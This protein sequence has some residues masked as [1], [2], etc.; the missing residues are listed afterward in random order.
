MI[1]TIG[2][3]HSLLA[4]PGIM[5]GPGLEEWLRIGWSID[6]VSFAEAVT[7]LELV[8]RTALDIT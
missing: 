6:P 5:F 2:K 3:E 1:D 4:V 8:I 7:V